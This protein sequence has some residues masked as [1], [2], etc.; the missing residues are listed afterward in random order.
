MCGFL[1]SK[2]GR[3][4]ARFIKRRG[5]D[6]HCRIV[7]HGLSFDHFLLNV[8]GPKTV[9]PF[10][11]GDLVIVYNGEIY[12]LPFDRSD[13]ENLLPAYREHGIAFPRTLDGEFASLEGY[14]YWLGVR[15]R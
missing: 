13:G 5:P 15:I 12:N 14:W 4:N 10:I 9:Q 8:T 1:V 6:A 3:G 7:R 2:A 11:D